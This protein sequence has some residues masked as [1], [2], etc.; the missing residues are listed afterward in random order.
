VLQNKKY[1]KFH[2]ENTVEV[3][4]L[5]SLQSGIDKGD[6]RAGTYAAKDAAGNDVEYMLEWPGLTKDNIDKLRSSPAG[7]FNQTRKIPYT[8]IINPHTG[9]EMVV[10]ERAN[11]GKIMDAVLAQKKVLQAKHGKGIKRKDL[12]SIRKGQAAV[13]KAL[14]KGDLKKAVAAAKKLEAKANKKAEGLQVMAATTMKTVTAEIS[15]KLDA[16]AAT[17]DGGDTKAAKSQLGKLKGLVRGTSLQGR[18]DEI[19]GKIKAAA[20][21]K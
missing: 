20:P 4:S 13:A 16:V 19:D 2:D 8:S 11:S 17:L 1:I 18:F 6:K 7:Q 5:G 3:L 12:R 10:V 14:S 15:K 9:K 21:A